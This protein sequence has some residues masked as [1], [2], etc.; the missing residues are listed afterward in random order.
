MQ[1]NIIEIEIV[2]SDLTKQCIITFV[3]VN[4]IL[5]NILI[6]HHRLF[7]FFH[8]QFMSKINT[9]SISMKHKYLISFALL[10]LI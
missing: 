8:I 5:G 7:H 6:T 1:R 2:S 9:D 4:R 3:C 10:F